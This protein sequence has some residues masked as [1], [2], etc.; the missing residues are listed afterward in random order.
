MTVRCCPNFFKICSNFNDIF[1]KITGEGS[2]SVDLTGTDLE[3]LY[4]TAVSGGTSGTSR[5][6][7]KGETKL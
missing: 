4:R 7:M 2:V 1:N 3:T 6:T 5:M